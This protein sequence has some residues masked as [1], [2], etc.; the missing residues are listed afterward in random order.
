MGRPTGG[1]ETDTRTAVREPGET[2]IFSEREYRQREGLTTAADN[3]PARATDGG[4]T[5]TKTT[6]TPNA[7]GEGLPCSLRSL[8]VD[9]RFPIDSL[10]VFTD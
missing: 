8:A 10:S 6:L 3:A 7:P 1:I 2:Q 4:H 9:F 5:Q